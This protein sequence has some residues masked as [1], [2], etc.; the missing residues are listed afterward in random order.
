MK[1]YS[2]GNVDPLISNVLIRLHIDQYFEGFRS[3]LQESHPS[4]MSIMAWSQ[5]KSLQVTV[6]TK[7]MLNLALHL[8]R[9]KATAASAQ[10]TDVVLIEN[11]I[12]NIERDHPE[13]MSSE[14]I[15]APKPRTWSTADAGVGFMQMIIWAKKVPLLCDGAAQEELSELPLEDA[16]GSIAFGQLTDQNNHRFM[17][18]QAIEI[19]Q[20]IA[21]R[22]Y[23]D[24]VEK[25]NRQK[26]REAILVLCS[27]S[28]LWFKLRNGLSLKLTSAV[29]SAGSFPIAHATAE[30][31]N[32]S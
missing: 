22:E 30:S 24:S 13:A 16:I 4:L 11:W 18:M 9:L 17:N 10:M 8:E 20:S 31:A 5:L 3:G 26:T 29:I 14:Q 25:R 12:R 2:M 19:V 6:G 21:L 15:V 1:T 7:D 28:E 27:L 32:D 23:F